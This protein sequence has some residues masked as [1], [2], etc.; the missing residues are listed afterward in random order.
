MIPAKT[1]VTVP[2][3]IYDG[4]GLVSFELVTRPGDVV[5]V[6]AVVRR[7]NKEG[8]SERAEDTVY[9]REPD[10]AAALAGSPESLR[11]FAEAKAALLA[12]V[13]AMMDLRGVR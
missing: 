7:C 11:A 4:W 8:W 6:A 3:R 10:A 2:E 1:P 13:S 12:A 5:D 9:L